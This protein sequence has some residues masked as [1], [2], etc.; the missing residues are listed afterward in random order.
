MNPEKESDYFHER[1][2][3]SSF[4]ARGRAM[5]LSAAGLAGLFALLTTEGYEPNPI[6]RY[7][8][9]VSGILWAG[10]IGAGIMNSWSDAQ[11]SYYR[12]DRIYKESRTNTEGSPEDSVQTTRTPEDWWHNWKERSERGTQI[13]FAAGVGV[14]AVLFARFALQ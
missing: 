1:A 8:L 12:A 7:L 13:L 14:A 4:Q 6:D 9:L 3:Q 2:K 5:N 11:W 10:C